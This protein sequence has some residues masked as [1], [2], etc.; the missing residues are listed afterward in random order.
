MEESSEEERKGRKGSLYKQHRKELQK[1]LHT[2][3]SSH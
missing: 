1:L 3:F 2:L